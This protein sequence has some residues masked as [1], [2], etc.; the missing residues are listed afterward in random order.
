MYITNG[1][2]VTLVNS[3]FTRNT[4]NSNQALI[5]VAGVQT[6][7][8][9]ILRLQNVSLTDN[10]VSQLLEVDANI[11]PEVQIFSDELRAVE[12]DSSVASTS[13]SFNSTLPLSEAPADRPGITASS[14]WL[15]D[16]QMV[17]FPLHFKS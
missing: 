2:T 11:S 12:Y 13:T 17:R 14:P 3:E 9:N 8:P 15:V 6:E 4:V 5:Q 10:A 1:A 16:T 7:N